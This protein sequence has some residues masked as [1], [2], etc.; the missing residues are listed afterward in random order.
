MTKPLLQARDLSRSFGQFQAVHSL[1]LEIYPGEIGV[2]TGPN[3]A[4]KTTLLLCLSGLLHPTS[5]KILVQE[6]DLYQ[7]EREAK[8]RLAFVPDAPLF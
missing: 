5:G 8:Q 1:N 4:G 2:L 7:E 6:Y 3:G